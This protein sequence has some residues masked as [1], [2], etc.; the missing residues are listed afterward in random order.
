[1]RA[2]ASCPSLTPLLAAAESRLDHH[3]LA[4]VR[5]SFDERRR[6]EH[7]RLARLR[8]DAP[9]MLIVQEVARIHLVN[10]NR[11]HR[12][13][14][15]IAEV[16]L[17]AIGRPRRIDVGEVV[18]RARR[19]G[20]ERTRRPHAGGRPAIELRRRR[21]GD[22]LAGGQRDD[23]L[24][25]EKRRE[26]LELL[27]AEGDELAGR[28]VLGL[29]ARPAL[30]RI[31]AVHAAREA[32]ER[33]LR[34]LRARASRWRAADRAARRCPSSSF[35]FCSN[36]LA[37]QAERAAGARREIGFQVLEV[38]RRSPATLRSAR[39]RDR[40]ADA[41]RRRWRTRAADRAR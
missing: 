36:V 41:G 17:L 20:F 33:L 15:E 21:D 13:H 35:S 25:L 1:M 7:D 31:A 37:A 3:L 18:V 23:R 26:L 22:R 40:R 16:L 34:R 2:S 29:R 10:R 24:A 38:R 6:R 11:P 30:E 32:L 5:P 9:Q 12:R 39:R 14:V 28:R 27:A 19:L 4:V 8:F